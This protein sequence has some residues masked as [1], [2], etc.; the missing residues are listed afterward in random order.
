M[1]RATFIGEED[2][3]F[4]NKVYMLWHLLFAVYLWL[5]AADCDGVQILGSWLGALKDLKPHIDHDA[6]S[7]LA[8]GA[9]ER[10]L[11]ELVILS[12][13]SIEKLNN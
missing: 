11:K 2:F 10:N 13:E 12:K 3:A 7:E 1:K 4:K 5:I 8:L 6:S 9:T